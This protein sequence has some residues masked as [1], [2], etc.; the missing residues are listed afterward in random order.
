MCSL[1]KEL[2]FTQEESCGKEVKNYVQI[3]NYQ[4]WENEEER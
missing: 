2:G 4:S 1:Q 3:Q